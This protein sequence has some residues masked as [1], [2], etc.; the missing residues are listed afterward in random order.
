MLD[1]VSEGAVLVTGASGGIGSAVAQH[2]ARLGYFVIVHS[3]SDASA[4]LGVKATIEEAGGRAAHLSAD[5]RN[6]EAVDSMFKQIT[7]L[8]KPLHGLVN[9]AGRTDPTDF[10]VGTDEHWMDQFETNFMS[11]LRC[12]RLA[13]PLLA[14]G[15]NGWITNIASIRGLPHAARPGVMAYAAAKAALVNLT[16]TLA[17]ELA[18]N[19]RVNAIAPGIVET[20]Y[21][22]R[23]DPEIIAGWRQSTLIKRF[24]SPQ[25][26]AQA[27]AFLAGLEAMTGSVVVVDGGTTSIAV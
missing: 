16:K 21:L 18:P 8:G 22:S 27:V 9:N 26:I 14:K 15:G 23:V 5:L 13:S 20:P 25:E 1:S 17:Q 10:A 7:A 4:G 3:H 11:A 6:P 24:V 2:L 19:V 12:S